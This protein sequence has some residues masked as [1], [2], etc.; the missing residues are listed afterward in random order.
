M[1]RNIIAL[2]FVAASA[3]VLASGAATAARISPPSPSYRE[4]S[5]V[6]PLPLTND[7][8]R[9]VIVPRS[10]IDPDMAIAPPST[11]ARMPIV[12][13]PGLGGRLR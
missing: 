9:E 12:V 11:G 3:P 5:L 10:D 13:P 4:V 8:R 2:A 6:A 1:T 7:D